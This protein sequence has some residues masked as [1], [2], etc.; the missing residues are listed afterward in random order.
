MVEPDTLSRMSLDP[1]PRK[2]DSIG[3]IVRMVLDDGEDDCD[4][5]RAAAVE[6]K[7]GENVSTFV[8]NKKALGVS[9]LVNGGGGLAPTN[10][11]QGG[12]PAFALA[13]ASPSAR[14]QFQFNVWF[15]GSRYSVRWFQMEF[16]LR[17]LEIG[18][19]SDYNMYNGTHGA[20]RRRNSGA[21]GSPWR[22]DGQGGDNMDSARRHEFSVSILR[23]RGRLKITYA[24]YQHYHA[25]DGVVVHVL[26]DKIALQLNDASVFRRFLT[27]RGHRITC[28][29]GNFYLYRANKIRDVLPVAEVRTGSVTVETSR[30]RSGAPDSAES[31]GGGPGE[32]VVQSSCRTYTWKARDESDAA[33]PSVRDGHRPAGPE[34]LYDLMIVKSVIGVACDPGG[35]G[36]NAAAL[37]KS[38]SVQNRLFTTTE[39]DNGRFH[40]AYIADS[41]D[42]SSARFRLPYEFK[43]AD[44][45][46]KLSFYDFRVVPPNYVE[47]AIPWMD[48]DQEIVQPLPPSQRVAAATAAVTGDEDED[49]DTP[50]LMKMK[51]LSLKGFVRPRRISV[52]R[53]TARQRQGVAGDDHLKIPVRRPGVITPELSRRRSSSDIPVLSLLLSPRLR[54]MQAAERARLEAEAAAEEAEKRRMAKRGR[55]EKW[56][57]P[58]VK[59]TVWYRP[60]GSSSTSVD[61]ECISLDVIDFDTTLVSPELWKTGYSADKTK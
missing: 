9:P 33:F 31:A 29:L 39:G 42:Y 54:R 10:V 14:V 22:I 43:R 3:L 56:I 21:L 26:I 52:D 46:L 16:A 7:R 53:S 45:V 19:G 2:D 40:K 24:G 37:R 28:S 32:S 8:W 4:G 18:D 55:I 30:Q 12:L 25:T 51:T 38:S 13:G 1:S 15:P 60:R 48:L 41:P 6:V 58:D 34:E 35:K 50:A 17:E 59:A 57:T 36:R 5:H 47:V 49:E 61:I 27:Y 44:D 20:A 11:R 23:N